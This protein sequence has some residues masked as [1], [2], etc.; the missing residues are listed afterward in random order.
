MIDRITAVQ[1]L[2]LEME[3]YKEVAGHYSQWA[4]ALLDAMKKDFGGTL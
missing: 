1:E 4:M 2:L 3:R